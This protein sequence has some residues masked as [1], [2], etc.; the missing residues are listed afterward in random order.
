MTDNEILIKIVRAKGNLNSAYQEGIIKILLGNN[1]KFGL[2]V[3]VKDDISNKVLQR[4]TWFMFNKNEIKDAEE[5]IYNFKEGL[6]IFK[7]LVLNHER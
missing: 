1:P 5:F 2:E 6:N 4:K 3:S 7:N